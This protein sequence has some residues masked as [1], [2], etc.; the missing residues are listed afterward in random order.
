[1]RDLFRFLHRIRN[2]LLF[3]VLLG[4]SLTLLYS[5][6]V[7]HRARAI[8]ATNALAASLYTWRREITDYTDLKEVNQRLAAENASWRNRHLSAFAPVEDRFVRINDT[9]HRQQYTYLPAKVINA[10][11]HKPRNFILLDKGSTAG[12]HDAMGVIGPDGIVGVVRDVQP[13]YASVISVL[14]PDLRT[15]VKV[16]RTGHFGL[17]YWDTN[18]PVTAS[19]V[20]VPKHA[21]IQAND[22]VVTMGGDGIFPEEVPVGLVIAVENPPGRHDLA[23][24]IR[25]FEDMARSSFVYVV[26][27]LQ[28]LE[29]DTL[30]KTHENP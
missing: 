9:I 21:R 28:R 14:N 23:I 10:T 15:S 26:N 2:T 29:R 8:S 20:D 18:D 24:T 27:D 3:L 4:L 16:K 19:V 7:L 25:L 6:N 11:W 5:G 17:L 1:M 30:V 13:H 22:T 12:L